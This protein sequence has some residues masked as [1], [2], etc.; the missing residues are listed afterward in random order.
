M[1]E[2]YDCAGER[3]ARVLAWVIAPI[4]A[5]LLG[6]RTMLRRIRSFGEAMMAG[7][8]SAFTLIEL[9]VVIAIVA[10]L[11]GLLLPALAAA[12]EKAR[13]TACL[14][15]LNQ[16]SKALESYCG[17]YSQ[18]F[19]SW[20]AWG[21]NPGGWSR[22]SNQYDT[23]VLGF[24]DFGIVT[25]QR[26]GQRVYTYAFG[27]GYSGYT[28][29]G[30]TPPMIFRC[31]FSGWNPDIGNGANP[32]P[33]VNPTMAPVGLGFLAAGGYLADCAV[34]FCPTSENMPPDLVSDYPIIRRDG[35]PGNSAATSLNDLRRAGGTDPN[36]VM[37]GD[38]GWLRG[39]FANSSGTA[40]YYASAKVVE[41][42]Y[43]Y[44]NQATLCF[45]E[46]WYT[47]N[48]DLD[49][50]GDLNRFIPWGIK[51]AIIIGKDQ[52]TSEQG[53]P[54]F[55]TQKMLAGRAIVSDAWSKN[56]GMITLEGIPKPGVGYF[57]HR[58][59]YNVL[60]GDWSAKWYGDPQQRIMWWEAYPRM[61]TFSGS[62]WYQ[63]ARL[64]MA[65]NMVSD[66]FIPDY[67]DPNYYATYDL[68]LG[69]NGAVV[70]WHSFDVNNGIDVDAP[71][72]WPY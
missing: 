4:L 56:L 12:R 26:S 71:M 9:L 46:I 21:K 17:D 47:W 24:V 59:G 7:L 6:G 54:I 16:F 50:R 40:Q 69:Q 36:S 53:V 67:Y 72:R 64:G 5:F 28:S 52:W 66:Y 13:R 57:G 45:P 68:G 42:H 60:Y 27:T 70:I 18:Y 44:R 30:W 51:P 37:R 19:P 2:P 11:A 58:D 33:G 22:T 31:I 14:N 8:V 41:S 20:A 15:N 32:K 63:Q 1:R 65:T 48:P 3:L 10:I 25:D 61:R 29:Y 55:K 49:G 38:W 62:Y 23:S 43:S 34:Y 39:L 35:Y